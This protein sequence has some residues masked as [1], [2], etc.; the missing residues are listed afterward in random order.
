MSPGIY[1]VT[2]SAEQVD[3]VAHICHEANRLYVSLVSHEQGDKLLPPWPDLAESY[4]ESS[5]SGV[6]GALAGMTPEQLHSSWML[7]RRN[8]GWVY[9]PVLDREQKIHPNLIAYDKLPE[10]QRRKD[11]LFMGIVD[12]VLG[13]VR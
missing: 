6:R 9:G 4:R 2:V 3:Q 1:G 10:A 12:A 5:R 13:A 11:A 8:Q 7:E